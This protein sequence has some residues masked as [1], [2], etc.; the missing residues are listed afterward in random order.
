MQLHSWQEDKITDG[1]WAFDLHGNLCK[2]FTT[3]LQHYKCRHCGMTVFFP[4]N[5]Y[6][7]RMNCTGRPAWKAPLPPKKE[8]SVYED[9]RDYPKKTRRSQ[10]STQR[11]SVAR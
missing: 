1:E 4:E 2:P 3:V 6:P 10:N 9:K 5:I 7:V 11:P 8:K